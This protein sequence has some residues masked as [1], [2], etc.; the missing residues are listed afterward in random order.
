MQRVLTGGLWI[1]IAIWALLMWGALSLAKLPG[2]WGHGVC[3]PWG[4]G[5]PAQALVAY[6]I[7]WC[8]LLLPLA[9]IA[10]SS[11]NFKQRR[12]LAAGLA[13]IALAGILVIVGYERVVWWVAASD[14]QRT[15]FWN[16]IGFAILTQ[17]DAPL[18]QLI[19]AAAVLVLPEWPRHSSVQHVV[20]TREGD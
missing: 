4:C 13:A 16:R 17:I 6:H 12:Y 18:V 5:P 9:I 7:A 8:I 3:G 20:L 10:R 11:L 14:W 19:V 1:R 2:D 15:F